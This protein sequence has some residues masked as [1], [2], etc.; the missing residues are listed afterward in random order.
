MANIDHIYVMN[1]LMIPLAFTALVSD[2][3]AGMSAPE[4]LPAPLDL[5]TIAGQ[6]VVQHEIMV[7]NSERG[8]PLV[9]AIAAAE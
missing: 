8:A 9:E 6:I 2:C 4:R 7:A 3:A 5:Q 1:T